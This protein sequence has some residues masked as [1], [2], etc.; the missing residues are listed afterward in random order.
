MV[1]NKSF[2]YVYGLSLETIVTFG[3]SVGPGESQYMKFLWK[4]GLGK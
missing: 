4:V 2:C 3:M 1:S